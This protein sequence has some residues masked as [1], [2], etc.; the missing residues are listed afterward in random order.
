MKKIKQTSMAKF[1][2]E[3]ESTLS[4][5]YKGNRRISL[6]LAKKIYFTCGISLNESL[7]DREKKP[8]TVLNKVAKTMKMRGMG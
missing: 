8:I 5:I 2:D 6:N 4:Q 3:Y 1:L 7:I